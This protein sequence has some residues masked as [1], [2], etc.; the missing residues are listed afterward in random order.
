MAATLEPVQGRVRTGRTVGS[1]ALVGA[2]TV[3]AWL[4][5]AAGVLTA[6]LA[7]GDRGTTPE[8]P[9]RLTAPVA[10]SEALVPCVQGWTMPDGSSCEPAASPQDWPGGEPLPVRRAGVL[11]AGTTGDPVTALLATATAWGGLVAG[12]V[13][14]LLLVPVLRTTASGRP[15]APRNDR[16]LLLAAVAVAAAWALGTVGDRLAG[17][18]IVAAIESTPRWSATGTFDM[19]TGW[20]A[21]T[22]E[23]TW[24][25]LLLAALLVTLAAATRRGARL[26]ADTEGLV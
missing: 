14:G 21:P 7:A 18:R 8:A 22:V 2:M 13:V 24:W 15:F 6:V 4:A 10:Y 9:V 26:A 1:A 17:G 5:I 3:A 16:R 20:L 25:P 11:L 19:P 12:G 23:V